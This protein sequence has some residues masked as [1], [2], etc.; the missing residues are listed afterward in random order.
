MEGKKLLHRK[1]IITLAI[2]SLTIYIA[3]RAIFTL[4]TEYGAVV[5]ICG[6][7]M[8]LCEAASVG[9]NIMH[10][11]TLFHTEEPELPVIPKEWY[12]EVDVFIATHNEPLDVLYKTANGCRYMEYP[13]KS[14][15]HVWFCDDG[16][17]ESVRKLAEQMG[18]GYQGLA[19]NTL[20]KAGNLNNALAKTHGE[21]IA[22]FDADMIPSRN[23]LM[24]TVPYFFLP[25]MKKLETGE[26]V[27]REDDEIDPDYKVG[28]IQ[29]PQSFYNPDLFQFNLYS[30]DKIP[31]EQDYFFREVNVSRNHTN[32]P[33]YAGSNTLISREALEKVGG[34]ATGTITEDFET[35]LHIQEEGY[36]CYAISKALAYGLAPDTIDSLIK[37]RERWGRGCIFSLRRTKIWTNKHLSFRAKL[38]YFSCELYWWSFFRRMV[39]IMAP[40]IFMMFSVP[41]II[42]QPWEMV[43]I[44]FPSYMI[45][46][47]A[48]KIVSSE[49][50]TTK[51][52]NIVDTIMF[53]Y[54]VVPIFMEAIGFKKR[55]FH[56]TEKKRAVN[57]EAD[58]ILALPHMMLAVCS[59]FAIV[60]ALFECI[61]NE[62][63]GPIFILFWLIVNMNGLVMSIFFMLGRSNKRLSERYY[64]ELPVV[65]TLAKDVEA[66]TLDVSET[67][68]S[69]LLEKPLHIPENVD[70]NVTISTQYYKAS[71][72]AQIVHVAEH[73]NGWKYSF[74]ITNFEEPNKG[75]YYQIVYDR[76]PSLPRTIAKTDSF[77]GNLST[78]LMK[79]GN[80]ELQDGRRKTHR[81]KLNR[82]LLTGEEKMIKV[83]DYNFTNVL[84]NMAIP[85]E[86]VQEKMR[87]YP[88]SSNKELY[89]ELE[90]KRR[91]KPGRYLYY[92]MNHNE[93]AFHEDMIK[94][95]EKWT[96]EA[97]EEEEN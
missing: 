67:G 13:D 63:A 15:V 62:S 61:A 14:K 31:N 35:G 60:K 2:I 53:P 90:Y 87:M 96:T 47:L 23:F 3:W 4:P 12:P 95:I 51:W 20:A 27:P 18:I 50:R 64:V 49:I 91:I 34:I 17:R 43:C 76:A 94:L 16:N 29:A 1:I 74:M 71:M 85:E 30:E 97:V 52:S 69:V 73:K 21:L 8:L 58:I 79:H 93:L 11:F 41:V 7:I 65:L 92:I 80:N 55:N 44:W 24:E 10:L 25:K 88:D 36:R 72:L 57:Q 5:F 45:G 42:C 22:T 39:F 78:N 32:S 77:F 89:W 84:L 40:M 54:L 66:Y 48:T 70:F 75:E 33:I 9:E 26:W 59:V 83:I 56:V 81:I 68:F 28:F 46:A 37:Q 82:R 6:L 86:Q 19:N 38:S